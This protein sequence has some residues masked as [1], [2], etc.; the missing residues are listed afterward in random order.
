MNLRNCLLALL[1]AV[2]LPALAASGFTPAAGEA[3]VATHP[4]PGAKTREQVLR[5]LAAW[6]RN[7]VTADGWREGSGDIGWKYVGTP[8]TKTRR[9]VLDELAEWNR[10]PVTPDGWKEV[11]GEAGWVYVGAPRTASK[12]PAVVKKVQAPRDGHTDTGIGA[13]RKP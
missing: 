10:N 8:G 3:G 5:E 13:A 9:Q 7:P 11:S 12:P 6:H 2:T 4:M 1:S